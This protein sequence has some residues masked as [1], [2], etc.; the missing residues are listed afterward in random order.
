MARAAIYGS[1]LASFA[2]QYF[3][4]DRLLRLTRAEIEDRYQQFRQLT[5]F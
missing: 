2:V 4:L 5:Q 3:S 1:A